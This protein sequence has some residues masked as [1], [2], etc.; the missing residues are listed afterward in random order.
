M[1]LEGKISILVNCE[2]TS[3]EIM[4]SKSHMTFV[5]VRL[6]PE[7]LSSALSRLAYTPCELEVNELERVGKKQEYRTFEFEINGKDQTSL[8]AACNEAMFQQGLHEWHSDHY[9]KSQ[10]TFFDKDGKKYAR[11]TIRRWL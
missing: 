5:K 1:K 4:D 6:T 8:E 10:D 11:V 9:Y 7:Q 2:Y 3:I